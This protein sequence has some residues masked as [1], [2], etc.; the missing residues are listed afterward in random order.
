MT[1]LRKI[2]CVLS[3]AAMLCQATAFADVTTDDGRGLVQTFDDLGG[4]VMPEE[5]NLYI[6]GSETAATDEEIA[7]IAVSGDYIG[8]KTGVYG[9]EDTVFAVENAI[10]KYVAETATAKIRPDATGILVGF[11]MLIEDDITTRQINALCRQLADVSKNQSNA[12][13]SATRAI[14]ISGNNITSVFSTSVS[15]LELPVK[16]WVRIDFVLS[17]L[18]TGSSDTANI[19][20]YINGE[21]KQSI[22]AGRLSN[23]RSNIAGIMSLKFV[24]AAGEK[25]WYIDNLTTERLTEI[26]AVES[27]DEAVVINNGAR[28]VTA[29]ASMTAEALTEALGGGGVVVLN[30]AKQAQSGAITDGYVYVPFSANNL[31][32]CYYAL[33][34]ESVAADSVELNV[35]TDSATYT[36]DGVEAGVVG[37]KTTVTKQGNPLIDSYGTF[38]VKSADFDFIA[39][40]PTEIS[41]EGEPA[42]GAYAVEVTG[43]DQDNYSTPI[44]AK[45]FVKS[46]SVWYYSDLVSGRVE[47]K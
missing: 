8:G 28:T 7:A 2:I 33:T 42:D 30:E 23:K 19:D 35:V 11:N 3:A 38:I 22:Q 1:S 21:Y 13:F 25:G 9:R 31:S 41:A 12:N 36:E 29:P 17:N 16:E 14:T 34:A 37:F 43:I 39:G 32:G 15:G 40:S 18:T 47:N 5:M 6:N 45:S 27:A 26:P 46:G 44:Y 20:L 24:Y 4:Y 10:Q